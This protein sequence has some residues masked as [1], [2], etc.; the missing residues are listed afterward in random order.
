MLLTTERSSPSPAIALRAAVKVESVRIFAAPSLV[1]LN[2]GRDRQASTLR[3]VVG[4]TDLARHHP[5]PSRPPLAT[6]STRRTRP[7]RSSITHHRQSF[8]QRAQPDATTLRWI[9]D[10]ILGI[11]KVSP[12]LERRAVEPE[13]LN[14]CVLEGDHLLLLRSSNPID[15]LHP[16]VAVGFKSRRDAFRSPVERVPAFII[17]IFVVCS[18]PTPEASIAPV[19]LN[20]LDARTVLVEEHDSDPSTLAEIDRAPRSATNFTAS[21]PDQRGE[22][23]IARLISPLSLLDVE[24]CRRR[25]CSFFS[26]VVGIADA[27]DHGLIL[28]VPGVQFNAVELVASR[29]SD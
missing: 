21:R 5:G 2:P 3:P 7:V 1:K 26:P 20:R 14:G 15:D 9:R 28:Q 6:L 16:G 13:V 29:V 18:Y 17:W 22:S 11:E 19:I 8:D 4:V 23:G 10:A 25:V 12:R 27:T 24:P